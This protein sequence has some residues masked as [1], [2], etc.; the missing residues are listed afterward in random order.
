MRTIKGQW[1]TWAT[2]GGGPAPARGP[3]RSIEEAL[4]AL[5]RFRE[6]HGAMAGTYERAGSLRLKAYPTRG[7]AR[8]GDISD[9][10][11][12]VHGWLERRKEM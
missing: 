12:V 1:F 6:K 7:K 3:F 9:N 8:K 10:G 4:D 5:Q 2:C 11:E